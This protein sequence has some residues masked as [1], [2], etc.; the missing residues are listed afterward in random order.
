MVKSF[1]SVIGR[2]KR[3]DN[4]AEFYPHMFISE[5]E[6]LLKGKTTLAA[7]MERRSFSKKEGSEDRRRDGGGAAI[8]HS[9]QGRREFLSALQI[10]T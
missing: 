8:T 10:E 1:E 7:E 3:V 9:N 5:L 6:I 2:S 4:G